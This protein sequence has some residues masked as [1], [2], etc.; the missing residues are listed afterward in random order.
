MMTPL[1]RRD[2]T[3][4]ILVERV[5]CN[6]LQQSGGSNLHVAGGDHSGLL[7]NKQVKKDMSALSPAHMS[8]EFKVFLVNSTSALH[9][10]EART[11][12]FWFKQY[13]ATTEHARYAQEFFKELV[14]PQ[15]FPRDYVGYIKK[16]MKLMQG[17]YVDLHRIEIAITQL[18]ES[19]HAPTR[20]MSP[21]DGDDANS[22][23]PL[24]ES[25]VLEVVEQSYPNP[26]SIA[27]I[28]KCVSGCEDEVQLHVQALCERGAV[29]RLDSGSYTR[30]QQHQPPSVV[31]KQSPSVSGSRQP[32]LAIITANYCEKLAVDAMIDNKETFVRYATVGESNVYTLGN[33]GAHRVVST[34]LPT[35]SQSRSA[36]IATGS[37]TTR[38]LGCF[39]QI[40]H[41]LMVGVGG[42]VPHY[43]DHAR[44]VRLG[45][46]VVSAPL[47]GQRFTYL[48][49][50]RA[51]ELDTGAFE[52]ETKSWGPPCSELCD[53]ASILVKDGRKQPDLVPWIQYFEEGQQYLL[54]EETS[55][56]RP[57]EDTDRL[58]MAIGEKDV[59]EV[60]HPSPPEGKDNPRLGGAPVVH[61]G[62][63]ASGR[64]VVGNE[65]MR[66]E[67]ASQ[68]GIVAFDAEFDSV[69]ES[70]FGSRKDSYMFIRGVADYRDGSRG[71]EWQPYAALKAASFMKALICAINPP[72][73]N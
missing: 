6:Q 47:A 26:V 19:Q 48:H 56:D 14:S 25:R 3:T 1:G 20:P 50:E 10:Q 58:Y 71:K 59:I 29:Q 35:L 69:V 68:L 45:D 43:T 63:V 49:C 33:I 60:A 46:V 31:F 11:L 7:V 22:A 23:I 16:V 24:T 42:A 36:N 41:V 30:V 65:V 70:V 17:K 21:Q 32:S 55:F 52:F 27:E 18:G 57:A 15:D 2:N 9:T 64:Q 12:R 4:C 39:Q 40:E 54:D 66:Q 62:P 61:L 44:H 72:A 73:S 67:F 37:V 5:V 34:K 53:A 28:A 38:L 51:V 8:L 13:V